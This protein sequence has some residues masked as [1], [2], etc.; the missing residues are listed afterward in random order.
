MLPTRVRNRRNGFGEMVGGIPAGVSPG[1]AAAYSTHQRPTIRRAPHRRIGERCRAQRRPTL[2]PVRFLERWESAV[3]L[4]TLVSCLLLA[5]QD[6]APG[7]LMSFLPLIAIMFVLAYFL[8]IRP[9]RREQASRR[10]MIEAIKKNDRV[11]TIGGIYGVV[12]NVRRDADEV[13]IRVDE[14]TNTKLRLTFSSV[15]RV[16]TG[17]DSDE[18]SS[19]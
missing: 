8:L 12:T 1:R 17:D 6:G 7:G 5:Q 13:T 4:S 16:V 9:Q 3:P 2:R 18:K 14:S 15:A 10:Q 19:K 11:V